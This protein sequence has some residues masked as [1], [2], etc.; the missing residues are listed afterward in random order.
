MKFVENVLS[1][2]TEIKNIETHS[3]ESYSGR[4]KT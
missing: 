2:T 3:Y 4:C 1:H